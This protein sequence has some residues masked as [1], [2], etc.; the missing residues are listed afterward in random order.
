MAPSGGQIWNL[1]KWRHL[2]ANFATNSSGAIWWRNLQLTRML[3]SF[4][5]YCKLVEKFATY[6]SGAMLL[7]NLAQVTDSISGSVV[8]M[9]MFQNG[10]LVK[11][12]AMKFSFD[13]H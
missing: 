8:P 11:L 4:C 9:A 7:P 1:C 3:V 10:K 12:D 2:V 6:A 13:Q 5:N